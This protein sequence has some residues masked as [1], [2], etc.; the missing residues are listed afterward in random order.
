[1][2]DMPEHRDLGKEKP[3]AAGQCG[4]IKVAEAVRRQG[5]AAA[6]CR[7]SSPQPRG[8]WPIDARAL[9]TSDPSRGRSIT[10]KQHSAEAFCESGKI[11]CGDRA[12][13]LPAG[14]ITASTSVKRL[15]TGDGQGH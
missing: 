13:A 3:G 1:M 8:D 10:L 15:L 12:A 2:A 6:G 4:P 7:S 9:R 14:S 11:F 5:R